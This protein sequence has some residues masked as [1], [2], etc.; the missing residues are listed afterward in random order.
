MKIRTTLLRCVEGAR[1]EFRSFENASKPPIAITVVHEEKGV[2]FDD[3]RL[4][5]VVRHP[6]TKNL[7]E[8]TGLHCEKGISLWSRPLDAL[9]F[10]R[11]VTRPKSAFGGPVTTNAL[12]PI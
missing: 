10:L 4:I 7:T 6:A 12:D 3:V 5:V 9:N 11:L 1:R 2:S 8:K